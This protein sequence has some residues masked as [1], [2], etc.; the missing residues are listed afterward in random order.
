[1]PP[2]AAEIDDDPTVTPVTVP[3]LSTLAIAGLLLVHE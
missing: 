1:M 3:E 2:Q